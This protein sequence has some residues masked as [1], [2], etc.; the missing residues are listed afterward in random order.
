L[1]KTGYKPISQV[2]IGDLVYTHGRR[3]KKVTELHR[4]LWSGTLYEFHVN[5]LPLP[6]EV[7]ADHPMFTKIFA[8]SRATAAVK[9]KARRYFGGEKEFNEQPADWAHAEHIGVGDRFFYQ[10][11]EYSSSDFCKLA[12]EGLATLLGYYLAEG[13]FTY[14]NDKP[15][16]VQL[17]CCTT[18]DLPREVP[19]LVSSLFPGVTCTVRSRMNSKPGLTVDIFSTDLAGLC[20]KYIGR[21]CRGKCIPPEVFLADDNIKTAFLAAWLNGDG[22]MDKKGVHWSTASITLALQGRDLLASMKIPSSIYRIVHPAGNGFSKE[23]TVEYT[24]NVSHL[25]SRVFVG[26]S[27][28][29]QGLDSYLMEKQRTKPA[30]MRQCPDGSYAYRIKKVVTREVKDIQTYNFEVEDDESYSLA[31]LVSHNCKVSYDVCSVCQHKAPNPKFYCEHAKTAMGRILDDGRQVGVD[32]PDPDYF[33]QSLVRRPADRIGYSFRKVAG[34]LSDATP[35]FSTDLFKAAGLWVPRHILM[36]EMTKEAQSRLQVLQK[37]AEIEKEIEGR[38]TPVD[39]RLANSVPDSAVTDDEVSAVHKLGDDGLGAVFDG[40]GQA[41]VMLPLRDFL[42]LINRNQRFDVD[43]VA[44]A[45]G[46]QLPGIFGK[47][48]DDPM[49]ACESPFFG[50]S[51]LLPT[52]VSGMVSRLIPELGMDSQPLGRRV[53]IT[54]IRSKPSDKLA[55]VP[56]IYQTDPLIKGLA[57]LYATYKLAFVTDHGNDRDPVLTRAA[58]LHHYR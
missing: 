16:V 28:K 17:N 41:K 45:V 33:E 29:L 37:L 24:L 20:D 35:V 57:N 18:D 11:V 34:D 54:I 42:R 1:T 2:K 47:M 36:G 46:Q 31:G 55:A 9:A 48:L 32:N 25:D 5:G 40:L 6:L 26:R 51:S 3:W 44:P 50:G 52:P 30:S 12:D 14:N 22:W 49:D 7:T 10:P 4:R 56:K 13:S 27:S 53:S 58:V 15:A 23:E 19:G 8:G 43:D 39:S 21:G 38:L